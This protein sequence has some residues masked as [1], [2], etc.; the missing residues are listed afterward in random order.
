MMS[1]KALKPGYSI[2]WLLPEGF[3]F[4][5]AYHYT[6]QSSIRKFSCCCGGVLPMRNFMLPYIGRNA[7]AAAEEKT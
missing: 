3:S 7:A 4:Y 5:R 6:F 1:F 2:Q